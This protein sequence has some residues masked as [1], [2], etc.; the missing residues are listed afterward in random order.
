MSESSP[1]PAKTKKRTHRRNNNSSKKNAL[2]ESKDFRYLE[3]VKLIRAHLPITING[4]AVSKIIDAQLRAREENTESVAKPNEEINESSAQK[5][6][7]KVTKKLKQQ[8]V[9]NHIQAVLTRDALQPIYLSFVVP[10]SDPDFPFELDLLKFNLTIPSGYP[11]NVKAVPSLIVLN[12]DIPRG[13]AVNI[14]R[15]FKQIARLTK[16]KEKVFL[17]DELELTL[18]DGKG[19][20]SQVQTLDKFLEAFLKQEKRQTMKFVTFKPNTALGIS[21]PPEA[22]P[23]P[24]STHKPELKIPKELPPSVTVEGLRKRAQAI[25]E[26]ETKLAANVKLFNKSASE[27][28]Y[29]VNVPITTSRNLPQLWTCNNSTVDIFISVPISY[30]DAGPKVTLPSNFSTNLLVAK[31]AQLQD[32]GKSMVELVEEAKRAEK[33]LRANVETKIDNAGVE[34]VGLLNWIANNLSVLVLE[35]AQFGEWRANISAMQPH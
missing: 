23:P 30:P 18:V 7:V 12:S 11:R 28:R 26:M 31:K 29:K 4:I 27:V 9:A 6:P 20:L 34:L 2:G 32:C 8:I 16:S 14:E 3:I 17:D 13:F 1:A 5:K 24:P 10:P 33:N 22:T 15:G 19:L 35:R 25:E 21:S